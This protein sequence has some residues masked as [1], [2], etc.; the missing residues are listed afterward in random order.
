MA[1]APGAG[2]SIYRSN[3]AYLY[4]STTEPARAVELMHQDIRRLQTELVSEEEL[5]GLIVQA[6]TRAYTRAESAGSH[7]NGLGYAELCGGGWRQ[8]YRGPAALAQ[9]TPADVQRAAQTY[10]QD[11]RWG[12]IGPDTVPDD[13]LRGETAAAP[14]DGE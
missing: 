2:L 5:Q 4:A 7:A 8:H 13:V 3:Y 9:V 10:L 12:I 1:Y 14:V 11:F 6:E